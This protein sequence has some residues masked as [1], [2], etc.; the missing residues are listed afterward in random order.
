MGKTAPSIRQD[1]HGAPDQIT[2]ISFALLLITY[3]KILAPGGGV[4]T[5]WG[6]QNSCR[7]IKQENNTDKQIKPDKGLWQK[8]MY[9]CLV[10]EV[11]LFWMACVYVFILLVGEIYNAV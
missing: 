2:V 4:G 6:C 5:V 11:V 9:V 3:V 7:R 10:K 1:V 8:L